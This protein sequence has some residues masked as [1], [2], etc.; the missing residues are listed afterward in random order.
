MEKWRNGSDDASALRVT[1]AVTF[2]FVVAVLFAFP[3]TAEPL[4]KPASAG[5]N[6][7]LTPEGDG[8]TLV[9]RYSDARASASAVGGVSTPSPQVRTDF[10]PADFQVTA[11]AP[12][13]NGGG[14]ALVDTISQSSISVDAS[15]RAMQVTGFARIQTQS[16]APMGLAQGSSKLI[17]LT[18]SL[19]NASFVYSLS[20][21]LWEA[22]IRVATR[23]QPLD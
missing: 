9:T 19:A 21:D 18:F 16:L 4:K 20:G 12:S 23:N 22:G 11:N 3:F 17:V 13:A 1:I 14:G 6:S 10:L 8:I 15:N 5:P 7:S 2:L